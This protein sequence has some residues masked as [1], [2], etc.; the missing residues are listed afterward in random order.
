MSKKVF[1]GIVAGLKDAI[2]DAR[3]EPGRVVKV[4]T[5]VPVDVKRV[6]R[7]TGL[8]RIEFSRTFGFPAASCR[9]WEQGER[10]P[11]GA[12]LVLLHVI[13][14]HPEMVLKVAKQVRRIGE[15]IDRRL[16]TGLHSSSSP[17]VI[18]RA[19][20]HYRKP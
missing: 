8:G 11:D 20:E 12:A 6:R 7:K 19:V 2:A 10:E 5:I 13:D 1:D 17:R 15:R 16:P 4:T 3:G 18:G 9:E 14:R